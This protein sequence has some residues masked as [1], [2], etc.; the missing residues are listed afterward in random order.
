MSQEQE[1]QLLVSAYFWA[2]KAQKNQKTGINFWCR[3]CTNCF[4]KDRKADRG[5]TEVTDVYQLLW[6][7]SV[8]S[9]TTLVLIL[10]LGKMHFN[11]RGS[12]SPF[13]SLNKSIFGESNRINNANKPTNIQS[14][15]HPTLRCY[16]TFSGDNCQKLQVINERF[17]RFLEE[18]INS[19]KCKTSHVLASYHSNYANKNVSEKSNMQTILYVSYLINQQHTVCK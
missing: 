13:P 2:N 7:H 5:E 4:L 12:V 14:I 6:N 1:K 16:L 3:L 10:L 11:Q 15:S 8:Q 18:D 9:L 17:F 19:S